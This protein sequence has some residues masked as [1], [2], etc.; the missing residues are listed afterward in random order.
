MTPQH[1][2]PLAVAARPRNDYMRMGFERVNAAGE[3]IEFK[4]VADR[5]NGWNIITTCPT[6][7]MMEICAI[8]RE[9]AGVR[10]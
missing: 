2:A 9:R 10:D 4:A 6:E 3:Y 1:S 5:V 8:M 7:T